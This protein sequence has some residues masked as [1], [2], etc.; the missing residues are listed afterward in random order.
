MDTDVAAD[1]GMFQACWITHVATCNGKNSLLEEIIS[2][3][4]PASSSV[5]PVVIGCPA[6]APEP[7]LV[8]L[9]R[10]PR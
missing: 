7:G 10:S 6:S 5:L 4:E 3:S 8:K 1:D 9:R 2:R